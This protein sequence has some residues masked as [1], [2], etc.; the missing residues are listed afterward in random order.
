LSLE[1]TRLSQLSGDL[2]FF[3]AIQR[4]SKIFAEQQN[5]S[6]LPGLWPVY[7]NAVEQ[8]FASG[9][10]FSLGALADSLYEYMPKMYILLGGLCPEY[11]DM[12]R[13]FIDTA[14]KFLFF[15]PMNPQNEELLISGVARVAENRIHLDA[16][17]EY[18]I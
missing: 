13:N 14:K 2:K 18:L 11:G 3:D 5:N 17:G 6:S 10:E 15:R 4:I 7:V 16:S 12:T 9:N 1:F 8:D